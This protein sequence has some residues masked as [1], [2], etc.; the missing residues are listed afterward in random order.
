MRGFCSRQIPN[1]AGMRDGLS[2]GLRRLTAYVCSS[3]RRVGPL[4]LITSASSCTELTTESARTGILWEV[5][6]KVEIP[7]LVFDSLVIVSQDDG[8][9]RALKRRDGEQVWERRLPFAVFTGN[10]LR[11]GNT[12]LVP[13]GDLVALDGRSGNELWR[14]AG[15]GRAA[16]VQPSVLAGDTVFVPGFVGG[17]AA[18]LEASTGRVLWHRR[19]GGSV[20]QP[21]VTSSMVVFP[22]REAPGLGGALVGLSRFT[23]EEVWRRALNI[24]DA[25]DEAFTA[26]TASQGT[27]FVGTYLGV[28][29]A[30]NTA[31]GAIVWRDTTGT[32]VRNLRYQVRPLLSRGAMVF[33]STAGSLRALAPSTGTQLWTRT[34]G[35]GGIVEELLECG[36]YLCIGNGR[37]YIG[38]SVGNELWSMG[39]GANG[40]VVSSNVAVDSMG[41]MFFG[42][43]RNDVGRIVAVR[44]PFRVSAQ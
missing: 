1:P 26:G 3:Y 11:V 23:G 35:A 42:I 2:L 37:A 33:M 43:Y 16:G 32:L 21:L 20:M 36:N 13:A 30:Y 6:G 4:L 8:T 17:D 14:F 22:R 24:S 31:D 41:V 34:F 9:V 29:L 25:G 39:G 40:I 27:G 7:P 12:I 44:P 28:L 38:D 19:L 5:A 18:A 10:L 15:D